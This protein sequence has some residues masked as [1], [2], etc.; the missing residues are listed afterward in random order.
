MGTT[1]KE[2]GTAIKGVVIVSIESNQ[3]TKS[4]E[5]IFFSHKSESKKYFWKYKDS[6]R[7]EKSIF[8]GHF[9]KLVALY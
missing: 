8:S 4:P 5:K 6:L 7:C 3:L 1:S 2:A 9:F